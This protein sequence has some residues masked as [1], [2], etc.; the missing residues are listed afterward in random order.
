MI[1]AKSLFKKPP[2]VIKAPT[3]AALERPKVSKNG[4]LWETF[5]DPTT[6]NLYDPKKSAAEAERDL[7]DLLKSS[8]ND[9]VVD[10]DERDAIVNGFQ[11]NIK[12]LPHQV[13]GRKWM[14][15]RESGKKAGGILADDMGSVFTCVW[16]V[17][18]TIE[19]H[20]IRLGKTIQTLTRIVDG[21]PRRADKDDGYSASTM[22][23]TFYHHLGICAD[24]TQRVVCPVALVSQWASEIQKMVVGL[25]VIEHHGPSRTKSICSFFNLDYPN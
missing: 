24:G 15:D 13:I 12:L 23:V 1:P 14:A 11:D 2:T 7:Q 20:D 6:D 19:Y 25:R 9:A 8:M 22:Y 5:D 4:P 16:P 3:N 18:I 21:R 17:D 10:I